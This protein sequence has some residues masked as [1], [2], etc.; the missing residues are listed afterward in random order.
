M[1]RSVLLCGIVAVLASFTSVSLA[2]VPPGLEKKDKVPPG[3]SEGKKTGWRNQYPPGWDK[4]DVKGQA[5]WQQAV[6]LGRDRLKKHCKEIGVSES[7]AESAADDF[8]KAAREGL[9]PEESESLVRA[10]IA[11]KK[12]GKVLSDEVAVETQKRLRKRTKVAGPDTNALDPNEAEAEDKDNDE[13]ADDKA[14]KPESGKGK[15]KGKGAGNGRGKPK[16]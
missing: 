6:K 1:T 7:D 12:R 2:D 16:D 5:K 4:L 14:D 9:T 11:E 15:G 10:N 3:F 8:E 13:G